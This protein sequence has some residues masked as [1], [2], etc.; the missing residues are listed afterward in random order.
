MIYF[1]QRMAPPEE[2]PP[3][4]QTSVNKDDGATVP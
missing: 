1:P 3:I 4:A 2:I